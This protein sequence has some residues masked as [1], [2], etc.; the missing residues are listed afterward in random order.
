MKLV[1]ERTAEADPVRSWVPAYHFTICAQIFH[2]MTYFMKVLL[3]YI[4]QFIEIQC[5]SL[6]PENEG[7]RSMAWY[8]PVLG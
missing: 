4:T 6:K 5:N 1:L 3:K 8:A 2:Q 7:F